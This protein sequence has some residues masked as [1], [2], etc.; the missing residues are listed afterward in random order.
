MRASW[1]EL[2]R[3]YS[4]QVVLINQTEVKYLDESKNKHFY[5]LVDPMSKQIRAGSWVW[6]FV[7]GCRYQSSKQGLFT[8]VR[9]E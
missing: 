6:R 2:V 9:F 4:P 7:A 3:L 8:Q 1:G 5:L